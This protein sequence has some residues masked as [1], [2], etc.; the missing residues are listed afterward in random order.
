[1]SYDITYYLGTRVVKLTRTMCYKRLLFHRLPA[2][3]SGWT[4]C[5]TG[6]CNS[7]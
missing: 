3:D 1:M 7:V 4:T 6:Y 5:P 2:T